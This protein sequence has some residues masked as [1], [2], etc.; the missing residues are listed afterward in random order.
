M[1]ARRFVVVALA[2]AAVVGVVRP[3]GADSSDDKKRQAAQIADRVEQLGDQA[4]SLGEA[5]N[6]AQLALEKAQADVTDA[7]RRLKDLEGQLDS[8]RSAMAQFAVK[9]YMYADQTVGLAAILSGTAI[10]GGSAQR[11]GYMTVALG[12]SITTTDDL[13]ALAE[14]TDRQRKQLA[15]KEAAQE[16]AVAT[17]AARK[18]AAETAQAQQ[19]QLLVK[20]KGE[21]ATLLAQEQA[22][23]QQQATLL[24]QAQVPKVS[25]ALGAASSL[26][27]SSTGESTNV[28][29][30]S[31]GAAIAVRAA[32][33]QLGVPYV[34][35]AARPGVA[36]DCSGL[37]MW[38]WAQAGVSMAHY[39]VTQWNSFPK[40][41]LQ[42]LR[43]GDLVFSYHLGHVGLYIGNGMM[44]AA[45]RTG[46][47]VK[48]TPVF[49]IRPLDG[50]VR[51]G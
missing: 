33:S 13:R 16:K 19:K 41:S 21:E 4:A 47:V 49:G 24:A 50:A 29:G 14:D 30:T 1:S 10:D 26:S 17:V 37:T 27:T 42:A 5:Y 18:K 36:F 23:R 34:F 8:M 3:A 40:V 12:A 32:L 11:Q 44:V 15:D 7:E 45:P 22:R 46:D 39:T 6:G 25:A 38:A 9:A 2:V 20:V 35:A 48:I 43:P 51:P 28:P 31:P